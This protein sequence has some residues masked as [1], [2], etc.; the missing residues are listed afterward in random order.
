MLSFSAQQRY[1]L[2]SKAVDMGNGF[3]GL[4]CLVR[5]HISHGLTS[6]DIFIFINKHRDKIKLL[7]CDNNG[8]AIWCKELQKGTFRGVELGKNT[9]VELVRSDWLGDAL[10]RH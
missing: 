9:M 7:L 3:N 5:K 2:L 10:G 8:F 6:G 4:S 1:F